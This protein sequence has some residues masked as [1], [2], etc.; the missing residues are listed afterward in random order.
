MSKEITVDLGNYSQ[1][2]IGVLAGRDRGAAVRQRARLDD[3]DNDES[4]TVHVIIPE[5]VYSL[6]SSF[7]LGMFTKSIRALGR[8]RFVARYRFTGPDAQ[9]IVEQGVRKALLTSTPFDRV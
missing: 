3:W 9:K 2:S 5:Y 8:E 4:A 1:P 6:N 7:F